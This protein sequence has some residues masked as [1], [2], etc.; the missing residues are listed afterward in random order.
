MNQLNT[1]T[2]CR[3]LIKEEV[4]KKR[5]L[6]KTLSTIFENYGFNEIMTP[7]LEYYQTYNQAFS[8][9]KEE[10]MYKFFDENSKILGLRVDMTVPIARAATSKFQ[11][12]ELPLRFYYSSNVYKVRASFAGRR[13]EVM[14][15]GVELIGA[16][17]TYNLEILSLALN[18]L[19]AL[20]LE[21]YTFELGN[22]KFFRLAAQSVFQNEEDIA[23]LSDLID[24]KSMVELQEFLE[25]CDL[26]YEVYDFFYSLPLLAG[27]DEVFEKARKIAFLPELMDV[28]NE[29]EAISDALKELGYKDAIRFDFGKLPHQ[30]YYTGIIFEGF[31]LG[32][33]TSILSGGRYNNLLGKFGKD[34]P[35]IGFSVKIDY[36]LDVIENPARVAKTKLYYPKNQALEAIKLAKEIQKSRPCQMIAWDRD[37]FVTEEI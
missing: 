25:K 20:H 16:D 34:M 2:G 26:D 30:D 1:P 24:R 3:D 13:S 4:A 17:N 7:A 8:S 10:D 9:F 11:N 18:V 32:V 33:G 19:D 6:Q 36:L 22:S 15:C 28:V 23:A 12:E 27:Y 37:E 14:D 29:M 31:A 35:A 5:Q 21:Q